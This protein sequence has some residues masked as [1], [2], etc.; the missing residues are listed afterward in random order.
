M[1]RP[2]DGSILILEMPEMQLK[3]SSLEI[4]NSYTLQKRQG[5]KIKV[6]GIRRSLFLKFIK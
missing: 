2:E 3:N 5:N 4:K 1:P 6:Y